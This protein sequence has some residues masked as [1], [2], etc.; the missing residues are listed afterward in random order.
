MVFHGGFGCD[1]KVHP[2]RAIGTLRGSVIK[3]SSPNGEAM[4]TMCL[5][6]IVLIVVTFL[7][8]A[9]V[10][11]GITS[12]RLQRLKDALSRVRD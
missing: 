12:L 8:T 11:L 4:L 1:K 5:V 6:R 9:E 2:C 10:R 3:L 7:A